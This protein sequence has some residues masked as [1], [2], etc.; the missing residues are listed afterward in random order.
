MT[1]LLE[2][3]L[4]F[5][6]G[7]EMYVQPL[8]RAPTTHIPQISHNIGAASATKQYFVL[9]APIQPAQA[10]AI[11]DLI[12]EGPSVD[13]STSSINHYK[14]YDIEKRLRSYEQSPWFRID[15]I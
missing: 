4:R 3:L 5:K 2:Q 1:N 10:P 15:T 12:V 14:W 13:R 9:V 6:N 11:V 8:V 7:E